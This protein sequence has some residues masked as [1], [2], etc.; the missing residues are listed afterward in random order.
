LAYVKN[1]LLL[2]LI[3]A[4][5]ED[6]EVARKGDVCVAGELDDDYASQQ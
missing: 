3:A 6:G 2:Y 1:I 5:R 4:D